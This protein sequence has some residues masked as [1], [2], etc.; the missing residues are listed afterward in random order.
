MFYAEKIENNRIAEKG[1]F[2]SLA[3]FIPY[4]LAGW[5]GT[6]DTDRAADAAIMAQ[7][8]TADAW[9]MRECSALTF[10][11]G[12]SSQVVRAALAFHMCD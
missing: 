1:I 9:W 4:R 7:G 5:S 8:D 10:D 11:R 3:E 2:L 12:M 6:K